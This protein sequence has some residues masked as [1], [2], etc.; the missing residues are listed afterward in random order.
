MQASQKKFFPLTWNKLECSFNGD[1]FYPS[2]TILSKALS[3]LSGAPLVMSFWA[4]LPIL[5]KVENI[6]LEQTL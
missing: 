2:L 6:Y 4:Y 1:Q 3:I 5:V